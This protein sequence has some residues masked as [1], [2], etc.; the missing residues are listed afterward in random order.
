MGFWLYLTGHYTDLGLLK[1]E[2]QIKSIGIILGVIYLTTT[3][4]GQRDSD[5]TGSNIWLVGVGYIK[6]II[7]WLTEKWLS[8]YQL[9]NHTQSFGKI[10]C[11][12]DLIK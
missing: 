3:A 4:L 6:W 8:N 12:A 11:F 7:L 9:L 2:N 5:G 1:F 10:T